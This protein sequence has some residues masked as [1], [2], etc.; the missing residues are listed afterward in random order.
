MCLIK[1]NSSIHEYHATSH[2]WTT[3]QS[4]SRD[5]VYCSTAYRVA[6]FPYTDYK[7]RSRYHSPRE[8]ELE[9]SIC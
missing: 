6:T 1:G 2:D 7:I 5:H 9:I 4:N 8:G 3:D